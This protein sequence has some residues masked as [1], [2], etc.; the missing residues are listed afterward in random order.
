MC[1]EWYGIFI[2]ND[3]LILCTQ[4][5]KSNILNTICNT[6]MVII[7]VYVC[8]YE[9]D[10]EIVDRGKTRERER[11]REIHVDRSRKREMGRE[12]ED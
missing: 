12:R 4:I 11:E 10:G 8:M 6:T 7:I 9:R 2:Q 5:L 3:E 1:H